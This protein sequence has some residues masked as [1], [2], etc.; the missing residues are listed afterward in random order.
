MVAIRGSYTGS[1]TDG[2]NRAL[3]FD[4]WLQ[5]VGGQVGDGIAYNSWSSAISSADFAA[6]TFWKLT[7]KLKC[8]SVPLCTQADNGGFDIAGAAAG[9]YNTQ[10]TSLVNTIKN[11]GVGVQPNDLVFRPGWEF[12]GGWYPWGANNSSFVVDATRPPKFIQAFQNFVNISRSILPNALIDWNAAHGSPSGLP[13]SNWYPGDSYVDYIGMDVY[14]VNYN[15][16]APS[17]SDATWW[18]VLLTGNGYGLNWLESFSAAHGKQISIPE[19]GTGR[20]IDGTDRS[21]DS[22]YFIAQMADWIRKHNV[23]YHSYFHYPAGDGFWQL[24]SDI[25]LWKTV[26][27]G[28]TIRFFPKASSEYLKQ[29]GTLP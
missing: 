12:N 7:T 17:D 19:W 16:S 15:T 18:S 4:D 27:G 24:G 9:T 28:G 25:P 26:P 22:R 21:R 10:Y 8:V 20:K 14:N 1:G 11:R 5:N 23:K 6:N 3:R 29:F 2:L 13:T